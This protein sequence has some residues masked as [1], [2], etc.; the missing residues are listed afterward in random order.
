M[1][2]VLRLVLRTLLLLLLAN[3]VAG[4]YPWSD[5]FDAFLELE[6]VGDSSSPDAEDQALEL[7]VTHL[8]GAVRW[9][10]SLEKRVADDGLN[11]RPSF[12]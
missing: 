4:V 11:E 10:Q 9:P 5:E 6:L 1:E 2:Y 8:I 3:A 7:A 12:P